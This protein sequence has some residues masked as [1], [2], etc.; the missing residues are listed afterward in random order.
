MSGHELHGSML[1]ASA[2]DVQVLC[3]R[4][5]LK[6]FGKSD[7]YSLTSLVF[8]RG[9]APRNFVFRRVRLSSENGCLVGPLLTSQARMMQNFSR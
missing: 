7:S 2:E 3:I 8:L 4:R 9:G 1:S 6:E 5:V